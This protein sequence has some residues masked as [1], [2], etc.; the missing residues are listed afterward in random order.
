[1]TERRRGERYRLTEPGIGSFRVVQD[2]DIIHL[3]SESAVVVAGGGIPPGERL[4]LNIPVDRGCAPCTRLVLAVDVSVRLDDDAL[5]R[6][7]RLKILPREGETEIPIDGQALIADAAAGRA[8]IG[9]VIRRVPVRLLQVSVSGCLWET[10]VPLDAGAVGFVELQSAR[11]RHS[12]AVRILYSA[13]SAGVLWRYRTAAEF[14]TLGPPSIGSLRG[15]ATIIATRI[16][17]TGHH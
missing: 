9:A 11:S 14:L 4:L 5:R 12:E 6:E 17:A 15:V 10:P 13:R 1:M 16:P 3:D 8:V 7:V 2:V